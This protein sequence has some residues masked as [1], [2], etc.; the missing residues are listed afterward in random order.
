MKMMNNRLIK[1]RVNQEYNN[2]LWNKTKAMKRE[3]EKR[4]RK[5]TKNHNEEIIY[6]SW[7]FVRNIIQY[8]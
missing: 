7:L 4:A 6:I 3:I 1:K 8:N 2:N 5:L